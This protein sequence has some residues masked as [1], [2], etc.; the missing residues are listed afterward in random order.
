[1]SLWLEHFLTG[2]FQLCGLVCGWSGSRLG[3]LLSSTFLVLILIELVG[4]MEKYFTE[5]TPDNESVPAYFAKVIM[6]V[7]MAYKM[8]HAWIAFSALFECRR[9]RYLLEELPPVKATPFIYRHLILEFILFACNAF[10]VLSEY[11]IR[12]IYLENL[13]YAYSLQAVRAR[14]LQMMVLVDRLD[15][16]LEQLHHRVISGSSDY[17][18]L[19]LD[20]AHL[21]KVTRSLSNLFG[22]SLLLLNVLCLGDW[23]IVCNVYFMVAY[24][25]V[26]PATLFLFG[27]VMFVVCPTLIK[28]WS[29]CAAC[30]RCVSKSKH[31]QQQLKDLPGQTPLER[32][33]IE[34]FALQIMQDPIQID[35]CGIYHLNLQTLAGMFFFILEALVIFL[36]FVSL[37]RT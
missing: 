13:R 3:R 7:N 31:L 30:H 21:A 23:I 28:I 4:E 1:M 34:G 35:V 18:T 26:L 22:L 37:V 11:T 33:Q 8:I 10:L 25:Q 14:Y 17:K 16:Q 5:E 15:G 32:S 12:G 2:Y 36:Q 29:I 9:F 24:L 19:R 20:Y 27:Q 6:G